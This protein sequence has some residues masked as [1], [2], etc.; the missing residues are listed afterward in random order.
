MFYK[1]FDDT[2]I[3]KGPFVLLPDGVFLHPDHLD[4]VT[5]PHDGWYYFETEEEANTFFNIQ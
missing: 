3:S 5:L 2:Y 1:L 4:E